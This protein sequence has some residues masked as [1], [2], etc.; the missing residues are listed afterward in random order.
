MQQSTRN[1]GS[2]TDYSRSKGEAPLPRVTDPPEADCCVVPRV[3]NGPQEDCRVVEVV[4]TPSAPRPVVHAPAT[5][6]Q[7][8]PP[9]LSPTGRPNYISS[10]DEDDDPPT[11]RRTTRSTSNSIM[12]EAMLSCVDIQAQVCPVRRLG[13]LEFRRN[14]THGN[15]V[16]GDTP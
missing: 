1:T 16:H 8:R 11:T 2:T 6:S 13:Y 5:H 10:Q 9:R 12:Q 7:A 15:N 14:S 4:P 3:A